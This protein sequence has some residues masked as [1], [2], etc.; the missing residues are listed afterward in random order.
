MN[1]VPQFRE[2]EDEPYQVY[3]TFLDITESKQTEAVRDMLM[4]AIE[5]SGEM[6]V[7]TSP[8]GII[9]YVNQAFEKV[10]GYTRQEVMGWNP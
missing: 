8:E 6:V 7:I 1:A 2:G 9:Q 5:Q 4:T 3:S 10:S